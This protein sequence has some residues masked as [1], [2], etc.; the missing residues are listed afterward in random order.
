VAK[1]SMHLQPLRIPGG[2]EVIW[3]NFIEIDPLM[4]NGKDDDLWLDFSED[5]LL[6]KNKFKNI[7]LD[8]GWYPS[9]NSSGTFRIYLISNEDFNNPMEIYDS[10]SKDEIASK[11]EYFLNKY[12]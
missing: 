12:S 10:R 5:I 11:I 4:I 1:I 8:L 9:I 3:N 6:I 2:W 7:T